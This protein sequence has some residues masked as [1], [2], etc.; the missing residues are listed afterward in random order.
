MAVNPS[1]SGSIPASASG[2]V[3]VVTSG[4]VPVTVS[5]S[6][7]VTASASGSVSVA[8]SGSTPLSASSFVPSSASGSVPV[9]V[10]GGPSV[11][12]V[13]VLPSSS[14][15]GFFDIF[16]L[17]LNADGK[18]VVKGTLRHVERDPVVPSLP[19]EVPLVSSSKGGKVVLPLGSMKVFCDLDKV[20]W[21]TS[22]CDVDEIWEV[23]RKNLI[24][25][26]VFLPQ[27]LA[28]RAAF[29]CLP[30]DMCVY[31]DQF[32]CGLRFPLHPFFLEICDEFSI[33][34]P[35]L[36]PRAIA[37]IVAFI[38][39]CFLL[40]ITPTRELF[41]F[42]FHLKTAEPTGSWYYFSRRVLEFQGVDDKKRRRGN[43]VFVD[44]LPGYDSNN[45]HK[46]FFFLSAPEDVDFPSLWRVPRTTIAEVLLS[47]DDYKAVHKFVT[48]P[49]VSI[50]ELIVRENLIEAGVW[51]PGSCDSYSDFPV[52]FVPSG[53]EASPRLERSLKRKIG[54]G[55]LAAIHSPFL[56]SAGGINTLA[57]LSRSAKI[58]KLEKVDRA[59]KTEKLLA[60]KVEKAA[61]KSK[62]IVPQGAP[63]VVRRSKRLKS[64]SFKVASA[65]GSDK[66]VFSSEGRFLIS[67]F[68]DFIAG[69][70]F[71]KPLTRLPLKDVVHPGY[72]IGL[73][74][75][76]II[77]HSS[78]AHESS[79]SMLLAGDKKLLSNFPLEA[80]H[81]M[82]VHHSASHMKEILL[83]KEDSFYRAAADLSEMQERSKDLLNLCRQLH[84]EKTALGANSIEVERLKKELTMLQECYDLLKKEKELFSSSAAAE[85]AS[86][87]SSVL[88]LQRQLGD[89][90]SANSA[91]ERS[92]SDLKVQVS[93]L[94]A[95]PSSIVQSFKESPEGKAFALS[96]SLGYF[97]LAVKLIKMLL[98]RRGLI[99]SD[100]LAEFEDMDIAAL[101]HADPD[102]KRTYDRGPS[103]VFL[104]DSPRQ[105]SEGTGSS[106]DVGDSAT[107]VCSRGSSVDAEVSQGASSPPPV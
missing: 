6:D 90:S 53:F 84:S 38:V 13:G 1:V 8:A 60:E 14:E 89:L 56:G 66:G 47:V 51:V 15:P 87:E 72:D 34:L 68:M 76:S 42:F 22:S 35:Q 11:D 61:G 75:P 33:S 65:G 101:I 73:E 100:R 20:S 28:G 104:D 50:A 39:R 105:V 62:G 37:Y 27:H 103:V 59:V 9:S 5:G 21:V 107:A 48:E 98:P 78:I 18:F 92:V 85:K 54:E 64:A 94:Q 55:S 97:N 17:P 41:C 96:G 49:S 99:V 23:Y 4:S 19:T 58:E 52:P 43:T 25:P 26:Q 24:D 102:L 95:S 57:V 30:P 71:S 3:S 36:A 86:L 83:D 93:S 29:Q 67:S 46:R 40:R 82:A 45:W 12:D 106:W 10:S 74:G 31:K 70:S 63:L 79:K 69:K 2:S 77:R 81:D 44:P 7:L 32:A 80:L 91:L 88:A 16:C